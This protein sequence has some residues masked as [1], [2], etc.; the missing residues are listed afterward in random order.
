M[1]KLSKYLIGIDS[2]DIQHMKLLAMIED[3]GLLIKD[4][5][6]YDRYDEIVSI[7]TELK[8]YTVEHF[9]H[10]ESLMLDSRYGKRFTHKAKHLSF[11][12]EVNGINL[13]E[14]D[15]SQFDCLVALLDFISKWIVNH[16]DKDDRE[17]AEWCN[18]NGVRLN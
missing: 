8:R 15:R 3:I 16:I 18:E 9:T 5:R 17:F 10:E 1:G 4:V 6:N 11:I 2:V 7:I 14:V 13:D 12:R